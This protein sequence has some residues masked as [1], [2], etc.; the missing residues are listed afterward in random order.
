[1]P[2]YIVVEISITD[3][4]AYEHYKALAPQS[5]A[6]YGGRYLVRGA[7]AEVLEGSW[8]PPRLVILEFPSRE[9]ARAWWDSPEYGPAKLIRQACASSEML[10]VDG[11]STNT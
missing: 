6:R 7:P 11:V 9:Q 2:S 1:M 10:L 3:P 8:Q 4:D 5:I